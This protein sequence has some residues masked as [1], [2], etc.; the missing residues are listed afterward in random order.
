MNGILASGKQASPDIRGNI[1]IQNRKSGIKIT[2]LATAHIGGTSKTDIK[3][4]PTTNKS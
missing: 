1:I 4:I 2:E 3:F